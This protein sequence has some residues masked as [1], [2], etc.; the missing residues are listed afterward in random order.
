LA[1]NDGINSLIER[2]ITFATARHDF[3]AMGEKT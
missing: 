2:E 1:S 3:S